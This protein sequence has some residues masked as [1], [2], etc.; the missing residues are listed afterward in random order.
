MK[1]G[2]ITMNID[3]IAYFGISNMYDMVKIIDIRGDIWMIKES[4]EDIKSKFIVASFKN[5]T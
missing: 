2:P 3:Y 1:E 5:Q 4:Y